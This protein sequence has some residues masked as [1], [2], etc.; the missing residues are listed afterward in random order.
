MCVVCV[1]V[2]IM[3]TQM[4]NDRQ[5]A[6]A[7]LAAVFAMPSYK[8]AHPGGLAAPASIVHRPAIPSV[9]RINLNKK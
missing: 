3:R 2:C 1:Q 8:C 9:I 6:A 7:I 4:L 5:I